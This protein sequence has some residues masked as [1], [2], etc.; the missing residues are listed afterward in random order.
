MNRIRTR[1]AN[2]GHS[3]P[4]KSLTAIN[5]RLKYL[6]KQTRLKYRVAERRSALIRKS[7]NPYL[8]G[9]LNTIDLLVKITCFVKKE[10]NVS[11]TKAGDFTKLVQ[12]GQLYYYFP[13][14]RSPWTK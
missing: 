13:F 10:K 4:S 12:G 6:D 1:Q 7:G 5:Y 2:D 3:Q 14:S 9:R 8:V 11:V